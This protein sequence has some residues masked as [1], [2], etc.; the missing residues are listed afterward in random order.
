MSR[1]P[2]ILTLAAIGLVLLAP[3]SLF[4]STDV[5][6]GFDLFQ[7]D[8]SSTFQDFIGEPLPSDFFGPGSDPFDGGVPCHGVP[9]PGFPGCPTDDLSFVDTI[10][11]RLA[12]A[13]LPPPYP[14]SDQIPIEIVALQ[15]RSVAPITVTY[16]GGLNP[17]LWDVDVGLSQMLPQPTGTMDITHEDPAGGH[18]SSLLPVIPR[19]VFTR[20]SDGEVRILDGADMGPL[21]LEFEAIDVPWVHIAPPAGSCTSNFCV[22]PGV[23]TVEVAPHAAHGVLSI[24]PEDPTQA[25]PSTWG[26]VKSTYR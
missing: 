5:L 17:E 3:A 7:T 19:Y 10:V 4:A 2:Q 8:P 24:C 15:L 1:S 11:E 14:S 9:L 23:V 16:N 26:E 20:V 21:V 12:N 6:P 13:E 25:L 18:F 22:N